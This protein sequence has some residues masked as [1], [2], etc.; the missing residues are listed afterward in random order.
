MCSCHQKSIVFFFFL[1]LLFLLLLLLLFILCLLPLL[2]LPLLFLRLFLL[3]SD[4]CML[5]SRD[6]TTGNSS[7]CFPPLG[8]D[9]HMIAEFRKLNVAEGRLHIHIILTQSC[10]AHICFQGFDG[11]WS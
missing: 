6:R 1:F 8:P 4:L 3:L 11:Q 2:L 9:F 10:I 7:T 5:L